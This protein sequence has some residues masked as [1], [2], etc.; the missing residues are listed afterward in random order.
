MCDLVAAAGL[1]A[2]NVVGGTTAWIRSGRLV[3]RG[4]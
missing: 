2:V 4:W 1:E 3:E